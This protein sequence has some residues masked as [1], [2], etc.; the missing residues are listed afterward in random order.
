MAVHVA[1]LREDR[2]DDRA[3]QQLRGLEPVEVRVMD[4]Q[5]LDEVGDE[6]HVEA[7][8]HP[9]DQLDQEQISDEAERD[10]AG[11]PTHE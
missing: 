3:Q 1:E 6:R 8:Q 5:V 11:L 4:A 2:H 9:A 7:L 10:R